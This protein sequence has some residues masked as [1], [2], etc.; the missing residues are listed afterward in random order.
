MIR[1][2][3][4]DDA[5]ALKRV[6]I[7]GSM[8]CSLLDQR[9]ELSMPTLDELREAMAS[10]EMGRGIFYAIED[11]DGVVRGFCSVR[12]ATIETLF[13]EAVV[14]LI[15]VADYATPLADEV[16]DFVERQAFERLG[17][18]KLVAHCLD[19][20]T[21]YRDWLTRHGF[22]CDGIQR[23]S[24]FTGGHWRAIEAYSFFRTRSRFPKS[25]GA[26]AQS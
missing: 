12:G 26:A 25:L 1:S 4:A 23:D 22:L 5:V 24:V 19:S 13:A 21:E 15:D 9:R 3:E 16:F 17:L 2:S 20:E 6:Y 14:M 11:L 7:S 18:N 8:R 10:K